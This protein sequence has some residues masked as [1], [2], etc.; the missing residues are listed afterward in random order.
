[1]LQRVISQI[2]LARNSSQVSSLKLDG[3]SLRKWAGL[4]GFSIFMSLSSSY[5]QGN[6]THSFPLKIEGKIF[7]KRV[8]ALYED[9]FG[10]L[11]IGT[12]GGLFRYDGNH[13]RT[14]QQDVFDE[15]SIPN[16]TINSIVEDDQ[17][18]LWIG[19]ESYCIY[20]DRV[21]DQFKRFFK[22]HRVEVRQGDAAGNIWA[23]M[24][25]LGTI[26]IAPREL[27]QL[28]GVDPNK[29]PG[30]QSHVVSAQPIRVV[31][32][33]QFGRYIAGGKD[34]LSFFAEDGSR[35]PS[36]FQAPVVAL[37]KDQDQ[38]LW[39]ASSGQ[40]IKAQYLKTSTD[41]QPIRTFEIPA[42]NPS[43]LYISALKVSPR[44]E[45]WIGTNQGLFTIQT[46]RNPVTVE[47]IQDED[48][49]LG[50]EITSITLDQYDNV[51]VGSWKGV[52]KFIGRRDMF[53][54]HALKTIN[55]Q[56]EHDR[57]LSMHEDEEGQVWLGTGRNGLLCLDPSSGQLSVVDSPVDVIEFIKPDRYSDQLLVGSLNQLYRVHPKVAGKSNWQLIYEGRSKITNVLQIDQQELWISLWGKGIEILATEKL[58]PDWKRNLKDSLQAHHTAVLL[59]DSRGD[60]W[61]GNRGEGLYQIDPVAGTLK[62]HTPSK[63]KGI[64]SDAFLTFFDDRDGS[65]WMGTRGGGLIRYDQDGDTFQAFTAADGLPSNTI[66]AIQIDY[67]NQLWVSTDNGIAVYQRK[68]ESFFTFDAE[69]GIPESGFIY[70]SACSD[71]TKER[72]VFGL[73]G[74]VISI[75][76]SNFQQKT[77]APRTL[78]TKV[79]AFGQSGEQT[80]KL[81]FTGHQLPELS[82][83][84]HQ[85]NVEIEYSAMDLTAPS[86]VQYAYQ[87]EGV[88]DYWIY[89]KDQRT[90]AVYF[91]L[92]PG[93]YRFLVKGT[94][95]DGVWS[96]QAAEIPITIHPPFYLSKVAYAFYTLLLLAMI[97][98]LLLFSR[99]WYRLKKNLLE[100]RISREKDLQH[101]KMRMAFFTD[102]SHELRTPLT[103]MLSSV[104][105]LFRKPNPAKIPQQLQKIQDNGM[106][107]KELI[108]QIMDL[109]KHSE[110][111][112][113]LKVQPVEIAPFIKSLVVPF[114]D[115]AT[116]QK[117]RLKYETIESQR[118]GLL[119][120][121]LTDKI[122]TNL[123]SNSFKFSKAGDEIKVSTHICQ[124]QE[125]EIPPYQL[126][127][128]TYLLIEV[129]DTGAGIDQKDLAYIFD[130]YYQADQLQA[131]HLSGTGIGMELV[132][133]LVLL[134]HAAITAESQ[135]G[136]FTR[137]RLY[138][139]IEADHYQLAEQA[140]Q[141]ANS[142]LEFDEQKSGPAVDLPF[143]KKCDIL[144]VEDNIELQ[145]TIAELLE[146]DYRVEKAVN[147]VEGLALAKQCTP[148]LILS[149]IMMPEMDGIDMFK[150]LKANERT[151]HIPVFFL[152]AKVNA[153]TKQACLQMGGADFIAKPFSMDF[154]YWR[155]K[156]TLQQQSLLEEKYSRQITVAP[157]SIELSSPDEVL[158]QRMV[159]I[160]EKQ[161]T[162]PQLSV[163]Y[164]ATEI[165]M[166]RANLYRKVQQILNDT[167][168]NLIKKIRLKRAKQIL[169]MDKF[170]VAEVA[171]MCGFKTRKYFSK[172]FQK[173]YGY[174]PTHFVNQRKKEET[175]TI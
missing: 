30:L 154:L 119:D 133:K 65:V 48:G 92:S 45:V 123:L 6:K 83:P 127:G 43:E 117:I 55:N 97:Y 100:Q 26:R 42:R 35:E 139:P 136:A 67:R 156:N 73:I 49:I 19:S 121:I 102:L 9:S 124:L 46:Q 145:E 13:M 8:L 41:I 85:N 104:E 157:S 165:G 174:T 151:Q 122:L 52:V 108:N 50:T 107:M 5:G 109:S 163:Q 20:Y 1:M 158:V 146:K 71:P 169:E 140:P 60:I 90:T 115:L 111:K 34:G 168:V 84:F 10:F 37:E 134:H 40:V 99:R 58:I 63:E 62:Q 53:Q 68:A 23:E 135:Q 173:E 98:T 112:F 166:S 18:N 116:K 17:G 54:L 141:V 61:I 22:S 171:C 39:I 138:I 162:N 36:N 27:L 153:E 56:M 4:L 143:P 78:I 86:K 120:P 125:D 159:E 142:L 175:T 79:L 74:G 110:G 64:T 70:N 170:Y 128:G 12:D 96:Q 118:T 91:D 113:K 25:R 32:Q 51:W 24:G 76:T 81:D 14:Y 137:F 150:A 105:L 101:H 148:K 80:Q 95:S 3:C 59:K 75:N 129:Y 160:I 66:T 77:S 82:L 144:I 11:W 152:T 161:L 44:G 28:Q 147:G 93:T 126:R 38:G 31:I 132:H 87:L 155:I 57:V 69:D 21:H 88:N 114:S 47:Q 16:N 29:H 7:Q 130:R 106:K 72:I 149:D 94:N 167:P 89:P 164:L 172:C 15:Y 103:L 131:A 2:Q 33:D